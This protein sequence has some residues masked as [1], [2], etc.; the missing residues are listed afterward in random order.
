MLL[1]VSFLAGCSWTRWYQN[2]TS[3]RIGCA[4]QDIQIYNE[5]GDGWGNYTWTAVCE[6]K[7]YFCSMT[8]MGR[9]RNIVYFN[10]APEK[11]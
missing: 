5:Q 11:K 8:E 9:N 2:A 4:P 1:C 3:G 10:C 6:G 7:R